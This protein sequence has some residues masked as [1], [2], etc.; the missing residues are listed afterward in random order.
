MKKILSLFVK[1]HSPKP[2]PLTQEERIYQLLPLAK[3]LYRFTPK[4]AFDNY[5]RKELCGEG[6]KKISQRLHEESDPWSFGLHLDLTGT[7]RLLGDDAEL[8]RKLSEIVSF[9]GFLARFAIAPTLGMSW[10]LSRFGKAR[11]LRVSQKEMHSVAETLPVSAFRFGEKELRELSELE[12]R[13]GR[14]LLALSRA[15]L[16]ER[17]GGGVLLRIDQLLGKAEEVFPTCKIRFPVS[18]FREF[19]VSLENSRRVAEEA[20]NLLRVFLSQVRQSHLQVSAIR[21]EM[22]SEDREAFQK[23]LRLSS[24]TSESDFSFV[25]KLLEPYFENLVVAVGIREMRFTSEQSEPFQRHQLPSRGEGRESFA[26]LLDVLSEHLGAEDV[27]QVACFPSYLAE[28][29]YRYVPR[30]SAALAQSVAPRHSEERPSLLF[31]VPSPLRVIAPLPDGPPAWLEWRDQKYRV[32][33]A[34]GP[35]R[36]S[37]PWWGEDEERFQTKDYFR[38]QVPT[39]SWLWIYREKTR[40]FVHGIW[41]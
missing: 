4:I 38:V 21:L 30:G 33:S 31:A 6:V 14:E 1:S 28:E 2:T 7:E 27:Q 20:K 23:T 36:I 3:S 13:D 32:S 8:I 19:D 15:H 34:I 29:S 26:K 12:I 11:V 37:P 35:E 10:A 39:G 18:A 17:F 24:P 40:W 5:S 25:W 41:M 9:Q 22:L 16:L